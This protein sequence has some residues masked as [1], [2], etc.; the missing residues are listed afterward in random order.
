MRAAPIII[1]VTSSAKNQQKLELAEDQSIKTFS[2]SSE[3]IDPQTGSSHRQRVPN[4]ADS[5]ETC[6]TCSVP[7]PNCKEIRSGVVPV[8]RH[9]HNCPQGWP[10]QK[11]LC[12]YSQLTFR[13]FTLC[14]PFPRSMILIL[15][16]FFR[17]SEFSFFLL[18]LFRSFHL[19]RLDPSVNENS[20]SLQDI[21]AVTNHLPA[22]L[23]QP[24]SF[25]PLQILLLTFASLPHLLPCYV[26]D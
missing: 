5:A 9:D 24:A 6:E 21:S 7:Q 12:L 3:T 2:P 15:S 14:S 11:T 13:F 18:L 8:H 23:S 17:L 16:L 25:S 20:S 1:I 26:P 19:S 22:A 10:G 4:I